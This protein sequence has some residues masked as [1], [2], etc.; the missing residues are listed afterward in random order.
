MANLGPRSCVLRVTRRAVSSPFT[1]NW[2]RDGAPPCRSAA[3][4]CSSLPV[5]VFRPK[6]TSPTH[7][8]PL[9]KHLLEGQPLGERTSE[10][11]LVWGRTW[12]RARP[13]G[14]GSPERGCRWGPAASRAR[15]RKGM[16]VLP[17]GPRRGDRYL[18]TAA[19]PEACLAAQGQFQV[20]DQLALVQ[21]ALRVTRHQPALL[22]G[23]RGRRS[24][25]GGGAC[26]SRSPR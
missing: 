6:Q 5:L 25:S 11:C 7:T 3:Q 13:P 20:D 10:S 9:P 12:G 15:V 16:Q 23:G 8:G 22:S 21:E 14:C 19:R 1:L 26:S 24:L 18:G 17:G 2:Q 4:R